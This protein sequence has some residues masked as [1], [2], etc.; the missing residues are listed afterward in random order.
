M[1][2]AFLQHYLLTCRQLM[3]KVPVAFIIFNRPDTTDR[4]FQAIRQAQPQKLFV[5]ADGPRGDRPGEAEKC[6]AARAVIDQVD[7][8]CEVLTNY[9]EVN[10]G[11]KIRVS[12]GIDWVFSQVEEA[13]ILEDD[14]LP[15]PSFFAFCQVL[16][17][18]YRHDE[19]IMAISGN[20]FQNAQSRTD[21]SYY[22]SR[23]NHIWG[24]ASWRRAWQHYDVDL[25][26]WPEFLHSSLIKSVCDD[27]LEQQFWTYNFQKVHSGDVDTWDYQWTYT[28]WTQGGLSILPNVNMVSN[29]GFGPSATHTQKNSAIANM[30]AQDIWKITDPP[31]IVRHKEADKYTF[32]EIF[33]GK[34]IRFSKTFVGRLKNIL[35]K[36]KNFS[37]RGIFLRS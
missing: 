36:I 8:D 10:L 4:V 24:W 16:L 34:N 37:K 22:F 1:F 27:E 19:R 2:K 12:S 28:C 3:L 30:P 20:N 14:C 18:R 11:C 13:I 6:A 25:K 5:I 33:C 17:D 21:Y 9:S 23:Y 7:W 35:S 29:I 15:A 32:D 26:T 31:F